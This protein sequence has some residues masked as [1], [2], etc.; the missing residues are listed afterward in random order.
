MRKCA[1]SARPG[2]WWRTGPRGGRCGPWRRRPRRRRVLDVL[3]SPAASAR[4]PGPGAP[5]A[6]GTPRE[7]ER[8]GGPGGAGPGAAA[9]LLPGPIAA[10]AV[11]A[12]G[13]AAA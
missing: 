6:P 7:L 8:A 13:L 10:A 3:L 2:P 11:A 4:L 5:L 1:G 12:A 9:E